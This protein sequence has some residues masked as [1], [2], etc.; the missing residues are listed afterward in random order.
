MCR[1]RETHLDHLLYVLFD[2]RRVSVGLHRHS[3]LIDHVGLGVRRGG[4]AGVL[5]YKERGNQKTIKSI[6]PPR[7]QRL[8]QRRGS[9]WSERQ[10]KW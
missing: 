7:K 9:C 6:S 8:I 3:P 4:G 1:C 5:L 2:D 10:A